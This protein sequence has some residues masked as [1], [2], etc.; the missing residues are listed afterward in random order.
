MDMLCD[1]YRDENGVNRC[2]QISRDKRCII[3]ESMTLHQ[4][5][6]VALWAE[7]ECSRGMEM[8]RKICECSCWSS[9]VDVYGPMLEQW[10]GY[11]GQ[12]AI[13]KQ[14]LEDLCKQ[15]L[16]SDF[17]GEFRES[18]ST[19]CGSNEITV[20]ITPQTDGGLPAGTFF[21]IAGLNGEPHGSMQLNAISSSFLGQLKWDPTSCSQWCSKSGM[22]PSSGDAKDSSCLSRPIAESDA[23]DTVEGASGAITT[24]EAIT[25]NRCVRWCDKDGNLT[26]KV[27]RSMPSNTKVVISVTMLNPTFSQASR[28][29]VVSAS[30]SGFYLKPRAIEAFSGAKSVLTAADMPMF[31]TFEINEDPCNGVFDPKSRVWRGSCAGMVNTLRFT[32]NPNLELHGGS[33][34]LIRGLVRSD[35]AKLPP[36]TLRDMD[37]TLNGLSIDQWDSSTGTLTLRV[38]AGDGASQDPVVPVGNTSTFALDFEMPSSADDA[39]LPSDKGKKITVEVLR[40][41][42]QLNCQFHTA[43]YYFPN[44]LRSKVPDEK[45]FETRKVGTS[46]CSPGECNTISVTFASN[47]LIREAS[48]EVILVITGLKGMD[49]SLVC[50]PATSCGDPDVNSIPLSDVKSGSNDKNLFQSLSK[51][52]G[53]ATWN[54]AVGS[55]AMNLAPGA[56][57]HPYKNYAVSFK[58]KNGYEKTVL[59]DIRISAYLKG[60]CMRSSASSSSSAVSPVASKY[61]TSALAPCAGEQMEQTQSGGVVVCNPAFTVKTI[62]QTYPWP[63]CD[64]ASNYIAVTL[65]PNVKIEYPAVIHLL[66]FIGP[67]DVE[68]FPTVNVSGVVSVSKNAT[69]RYGVTHA[70]K[71]SSNTFFLWSDSSDKV[72]LPLWAGYPLIAGD[73]YVFAFGVRNPK[74]TQFVGSQAPISI[75]VRG[76]IFNISMPLDHNLTAVPI[77]NRTFPGDAAALRVNAPAFVQKII[78][79]SNPYPDALNTLTVTLVPNIAMGTESPNNSSHLTSEITLSGLISTE[80]HSSTLAITQSSPSSSV[81]NSNAT[82]SRQ[83][84][85]LVVSFKNLTKWRTSDAAIIFSFQIKNPGICQSSPDVMVSAT[86]E[87]TNCPREIQ[88]AS[89][90]KD[91]VTVPFSTCRACGAVGDHC[92]ACDKCDQLCDDADASPL[93]VHS[94]AFIIKEVQQETTWPGA[95]NKFNVS[96]AANIDLTGNSAIFLSG[97]VGGTAPNGTLNLTAGASLFDAVEWHNGDKVL[98]LNVASAGIT[99]GT[100]NTFKFKL[101]NPLQAQRAPLIMIWALNAGSCLKPVPKCTMDRPTTTSLQPLTVDP[102][103]FTARAIGQSSPFTPT[104]S[105]I[106]ATLATNFALERPTKVT[107]MGLIGS[108]IEDNLALKVTTVAGGNLFETTGIW[109][110]GTG[111]LVLSLIESASSVPG[112]TYT[113]SID[114]MNPPA[115][116]NN[117]LVSVTAND[118]DAV[119][120]RSWPNANLPAGD[121]LP[122]KVIK[123]R[124]VTAKIS[125][126]SAFPGAR[127][128]ITVTLRMNAFIQSTSK[129]SFTITGLMGAQRRTGPIALQSPA[130]CNGTATVLTAL[131]SGTSCMNI[132]KSSPTGAPGTGWWQGHSNQGEDAQEGSMPQSLVL[133]VANGINANVDYVFSFDVQNPTCNHECSTVSIIANGLDF[134]PA[135]CGGEINSFIASPV[136]SKTA[137]MQDM[138]TST[139]CAGLVH[140]PNFNV[141]TITECSTV[142]GDPNAITVTL[143]P[144]VDLKQGSILSISGLTGSSTDAPTLEIE[145]PD[146]TLFSEV[147]W[148][149]REGELK[150]KIRDVSGISMGQTVVFSFSLQNPSNQVT[151]KEPTVGVESEDVIIGDSV[152]S[153]L[154]LGAGDRPFF[155]LASISES[156]SV[157]RTYNTL[158]ILINSN[159]RIPTS[160]KI[161]LTGL[162]GTLP[163]TESGQIA[164]MHPF[165]FGSNP[166]WNHASGTLV[167]EVVSAIPPN[168]NRMFAFEVKNSDKPQASQTVGITVNC[169]KNMLGCPESGFQMS[170]VKCSAGGDDADCRPEGFKSTLNGKVLSAATKG[171]FMIKSIGQQNPYPGEKNTLTVTLAS[172]V[173]FRSGG[174]DSAMVTLTGLRGATVGISTTEVK[175]AGAHPFAQG[176]LV[177]GNLSF[178][179][180][181]DMIAGRQY[182]FSIDILNPLDAA[183]P[184]S[185]KY[186]QVLG[187]DEVQIGM[188]WN[189]VG[190]TDFSSMTHDLTT[191]PKGV[192]QAKQREAA[193]LTVRSAEFQTKTISQSSP[194]PCDDN[195]ICATLVSSVPLSSEKESMIRIST[196][197]GATISSGSGE[198]SLYNSSDGVGGSVPSLQSATTNGNVSKG[199]WNEQPGGATLIMYAACR[200]EAGTEISMCFKVKNPIDPS[201]K[202]PIKIFSSDGNLE[203]DMDVK[204]TANL[205]LPYGGIDDAHPMYIRVPRFE[206]LEASQASPFPVDENLISITLKSNVPFLNVASCKTVV[207]VTGLRGSITPSSNAHVVNNDTS[208]ALARNGVWEMATGTFSINVTG[209]VAAGEAIALKIPLTN[210][211]YKQDEQAVLV[212]T[213]GIVVASTRAD[214][215]RTPPS[216]VLTKKCP[217]VS[218]PNCGDGDQAPMYIYE[219]EF[220]VAE[221]RQTSNWPGA[222]NKLTIEFVSNAKLD[223]HLGN[224]TVSTKPDKS[225]AP[226]PFI[227][228]EQRDG[229]FC[230][231]SV[232]SA[233]DLFILYSEEHVR[234]RFGQVDDKNAHFACV[235]A[236]NTYTIRTEAWSYINLTHREWKVRP[237]IS[238]N[239]S[240]TLSSFVNTT[241]GGMTGAWSIQRGAS[242]TLLTGG[243]DD[244]WASYSVNTHMLLDSRNVSNPLRQILVA[245]DCCVTCNVSVYV[246]IDLGENKLDTEIN[247]WLYGGVWNNNGRQYCGQKA[248]LSTQS[249]FSTNTTVFACGTFAEWMR[250]GDETRAGKTIRIDPPRVARYVRY[251]TSRS[252]VDSDAH[253]TEIRVRGTAYNPT[254]L[255][256]FNCSA[257]PGQPWPN[258]YYINATTNQTINCTIPPNVTARTNQTVHMN[259]SQFYVNHTTR[260][261]YDGDKWVVFEAQPTDLLVANVTNGKVFSMNHGIVN[262]YDMIGG[263]EKM[264]GGITSGFVAADSDLVFTAGDKKNVKISGDFLTP[265]VVALMGPAAKLF[266]T[267]PYTPNHRTWRQDKPP[268]GLDPWVSPKDKA[269]VGSGK[270]SDEAGGRAVLFLDVKP[271]R[272]VQLGERT[273]FSFYLLNPVQAQDPQDFEIS[274]MAC[275]QGFDISAESCPQIKVTHMA[276]R[277]SEPSSARA[278]GVVDPKFLVKKAGQTS[279]FPCS[280]NILSITLSS[281]I[282][283]RGR[284]LAKIIVTNFD[285]AIVGDTDTSVSLVDA[286]G[287]NDH[288][289][290]FKDK[291][292][293]WKYEAQGL[294]SLELKVHDNKNLIAGRANGFS[295]EIENPTVNVLN[296]VVESL[297]RGALT[298]AV[299]GGS[300]KAAWTAPTLSVQADSAALSRK[301]ILPAISFSSDMDKECASLAMCANTVSGDASPLFIYRPAFTRANISQSSAFHCQENIISVTIAANVPLCAKDCQAQI[302]IKNLNGAVVNNGD[303]QL[304]ASTDSGHANDKDTFAASPKGTP[305]YGKWMDQSLTLFLT[306]CLECNKEYRFSFKV[307]NQNCFHEVAETIT[308]ESSNADNNVAIAQTPMDTSQ[309]QLTLGGQKDHPATPQA[310]MDRHAHRAKL[311][312]AL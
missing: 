103:F 109:T 186:V 151:P 140:A 167:L 150:M 240:V 308:I 129:G 64:G 229:V 214:V 114:L 21:T 286:S 13:K 85:K 174:E 99:A 306:C 282:H 221:I 287:G 44:L 243:W 38:T 275:K 91:A 28:P 125:Q 225:S 138:S 281:N 210:R 104:Q 49:N 50:N 198:I 263:G 266:R 303:I 106:T 162:K 222:S 127:N 293:L 223:G 87:G 284:D 136:A 184:Y 213:S 37:G 227:V 157:Q 112:Q 75:Q 69:I 291:A 280:T 26:V 239:A 267:G 128:V 55:L 97:F 143:S 39:P 218:G 141:K 196:F 283:L 296:G 130:S 9:I 241:R 72:T 80:T 304:L 36:P 154:V 253:F 33:Q 245:D 170:D 274:A 163:M 57:L 102:K 160:S 62:G 126:S 310:K 292:G 152:M 46:T 76:P 189:G 82:W 22:C 53:L 51:N 96:F 81:L 242:T 134:V 17:N 35:S 311:Q 216:K 301:N 166:L 83:D 100:T 231:V 42:P 258:G 158:M 145:G 220:L 58:L 7:P 71:N 74:A 232:A 192:F 165:Y 60:A 215:G 66:H 305:G 6:E 131:P 78:G 195:W 123:P 34:I 177:A 179:L 12:V 197:K 193:P 89:M 248:V 40:A 307:T 234:A 309:Q 173:E 199:F 252:T 262:D 68:V 27:L 230:G 273:V 276:P 164:G 90:D 98:Y 299:P 4:S 238:H 132:F 172:S 257:R 84:G 139:S 45:S 194:Y 259:S 251:Y 183:V 219:P 217:F 279:P 264:I 119:Q 47:R 118:V 205:G 117:P 29:L 153:G 268:N 94:P 202:Q 48:D 111:T 63:G 200:I 142:N 206:V 188:G 168:A 59:N 122:M 88:V 43:E 312:R 95:E 124:I 3:D 16:V 247:R 228:G 191:V 108:T 180:V 54:A 8:K 52:T 120:T 31:T 93:K 156:T 235:K 265:P 147:M 1:A 185:N 212:S 302:T 250:C 70:D 300:L 18:S 113:I 207:T 86:S 20:E 110:R 190:A 155:N 65:V 77:E 182:V 146:S 209:A 105:T 211:A 171:K 115:A 61:S 272:A 236:E 14:V 30:G 25:S 278:L 289:K 149:K 249:D 204:S 23:A 137:V 178:R 233:N 294:Q 161:T 159:S 246:Q 176:S 116:Q 73:E 256:L 5:L 121:Q 101:T 175:L 270:M 255:K 295:F 24:S 290:L 288:D 254:P 201:P 41:G 135:S 285:G 260:S 187:E 224:V 67:S 203:Q 169:P 271:D 237:V 56:E 269:L 79:Q 19:Q 226:A 148:S 297:P 181:A 2:E 261:Y 208:Y 298:T 92:N 133:F 11:D 107:L 32:V 10:G 244:G 277:A 15:G 144:N